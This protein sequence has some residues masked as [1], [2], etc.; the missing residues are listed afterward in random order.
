MG[1]WC[2]VHE[3]KVMGKLPKFLSIERRS[4]VRHDN[5][6]YAFSCKEFPQV[7]N[8]LEMMCRC[9]WKHVW[10][11]A[12]VICYYEVLFPKWSWKKSTPIFTQ[13]PGGTSWVSASRLVDCCTQCMSDT[14]WCSWSHLLPCRA[15]KHTFWPGPL[16]C[17]YRHGFHGGLP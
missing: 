8:G 13:G 10:E 11:L 3:V 2:G 15:S 1:W 5:S 7:S 14:T 9:H 4:V 6:G 17:W 12:E 16:P